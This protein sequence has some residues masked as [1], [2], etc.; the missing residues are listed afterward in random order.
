MY[1]MFKY[2]LVHNLILLGLVWSPPL[3]ELVQKSIGH[4]GRSGKML[5]LIKIENEVYI[6]ASGIKSTVDIV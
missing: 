2:V 3:Y 4:M 6:S 5:N 1:S